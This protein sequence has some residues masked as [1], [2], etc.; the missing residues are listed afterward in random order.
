MGYSDLCTS[1]AQEMLSAGNFVLSQALLRIAWQEAVMATSCH[2]KLREQKAL[3]SIHPHAHIHTYKH[4]FIHML[5][6]PNIYIYIHTYIHT[7][8]IYV[9]MY[10]HNTRYHAG[11]CSGRSSREWVPA[12]TCGW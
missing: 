12:R 1:G 11:T 10:I 4:T 8:I 6:T 5:Y 9:C 3:L 2:E 7:Y